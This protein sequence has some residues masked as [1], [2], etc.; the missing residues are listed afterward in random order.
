MSLPGIPNFRDAGGLAS[1]TLRP[2]VVFRSAQLVPLS[3]EDARRLVALDV[4]S[5][6]DLRTLDE[7]DH[8]PDELPPGVQ[9]T[10]LDVLAD[11]PHS[12]AAA[13]ASLVTAKKDRTTV[14]DVNDAV[15]DGRA[16]DL[17][18]ET[19]RHLVS[20]PSAHTAYRTLL[21]SLATANG[22]AVIHCTAGKDRTGWAIAVLQRLC[23]AS[24]DDVMADY[25]LSNTGMET[26]YR[27]MLDDFASA[28][29][30]AESLSHMI[31][32]RPEYLEAAVT[33][34][35][36]VYGG[37]DGYLTTGLGLDRATIS[38]LRDRLSS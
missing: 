16:R 34:M 1:G 11:R 26:A 31:F 5:V 6:F 38:T 37:I 18:I 32:V 9:V 4:R 24:M 28:G 2:G 19:Y 7:V 14:E 21:E 3:D 33:L 22:S 27:R 8:L 29:G 23:G 36:N 25:V 10:V 13:V 20:L 35:H 15:S 12:G 17:M 30:D